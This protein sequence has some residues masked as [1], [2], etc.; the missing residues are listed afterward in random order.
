MVYTPLT[1]YSSLNL[2]TLLA[3]DAPCQELR[4]LS[5]FNQSPTMLFCAAAA[6]F[7]SRFCPHNRMFLSKE[8]RHWVSLGPNLLPRL[9]NIEVIA[10]FFSHGDDFMKF[11]KLENILPRYSSYR[12]GAILTEI[13]VSRSPIYYTREKHVQS[14]MTNRKQLVK[15]G[16]RGANAEVLSDNNVLY[17]SFTR[18]TQ[19][20]Q[21]HLPFRFLAFSRCLRFPS[22]ST[23][24]IHK[25]IL[26]HEQI[27]FCENFSKIP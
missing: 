9:V 18:I 21:G 19:F 20:L 16:E 3:F 7:V 23:P 15:G 14:T 11:W 2:H 22:R 24:R 5:R 25:V 1:K 10:R 17:V 12:D 6:A 4:N 13:K 27:S 8:R 26:W